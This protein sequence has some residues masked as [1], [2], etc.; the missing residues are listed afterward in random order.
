MGGGE[1][2]ASCV[3]EGWPQRGVLSRT[4]T[5]KL[6]TLEAP[7]IMVPAPPLPP[8]A[9]VAP[10]WVLTPGRAPSSRMVAEEEGCGVEESRSGLRPLT[11]AYVGNALSR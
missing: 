4:C 1:G 5:S 3:N 10:A 9:V 2:R 11:H 6:C 8:T 7:F